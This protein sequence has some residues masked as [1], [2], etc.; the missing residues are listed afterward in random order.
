MRFLSIRILLPI[1]A[2]LFL[3]ISCGE[4][5]KADVEQSQAEDY[6]SLNAS[7]TIVKHY[8]RKLD[9]TLLETSTLAALLNNSDPAKSALRSRDRDV[10]RMYEIEKPPLVDTLSDDYNHRSVIEA[11]KVVEDANYAIE[12]IKEEIEAKKLQYAQGEIDPER[13]ITQEFQALMKDYEKIIRE[14]ENEVETLQKKIDKV[15]KKQVR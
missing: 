8:V 5:K 11:N 1:A 13:E 3:L 9:S 7:I 15:V 2:L 12:T 14:A 6:D 10:V 4:E